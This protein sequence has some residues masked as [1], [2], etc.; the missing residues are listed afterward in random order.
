MTVQKRYESVAGGGV[1]VHLEFSKVTMSGSKGKM[2]CRE[3]LEHRDRA[4]LRRQLAQWPRGLPV[5]LEASF[6]WGWLSDEMEAA[7]L[8]VHLS[9]C[10]KVEQMRKARGLVKTNDKDSELLSLLPQEATNWWE[11][12][13]PPA[14]VRDLR[15]LTRLWATMKMLDVQVKNRIHGLFHRHGVFHDFKDL[16]GGPGRTFLAELC[17]EGRFP[18]GQ[19][20]SGALTYLREQVRLLEHLRRSMAELSKQLHRL[21]E[22][23][24]LAQRIDEVPGIGL[25]LTEVLLA[26]IGD[27]RRFRNEGA[28]ACYCLL[29]PRA[30]DTGEE[31]PDK[32][33]FGRHLGYR[34]NHTLK[35]AFIQ[36]AH[37]AVRK[38]GRWRAMFDRATD[39]GRNNR[40]RGYIKVARSLVQVVDLIWRRG[41]RYAPCPPPRPGSPSPDAGGGRRKSAAAWYKR[42]TRSGTGQL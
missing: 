1:D 13:R 3:R 14:E 30:H 11:V 31:T 33:V 35:W 15:E 25:L 24:E 40:G 42:D 8:E 41:V 27:I 38:G 28:L 34:G 21:L 22:Q 23:S 26:E 29:A 16:F 6:G 2:I 12:W 19:L 18:H 4:A 10:F 17:V 32:P 36:A 5:V 9:N 39:G 7:G 20:L 37:G